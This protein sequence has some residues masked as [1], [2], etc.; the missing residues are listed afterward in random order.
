MPQKRSRLLRA[1]RTDEAAMLVAMWRISEAP[2]HAIGGGC[3]HL[4]REG[5]QPTWLL[6]RAV[7]E[8][9]GTLLR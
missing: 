3:Y 5:T 2:P 1:V 4:V 8:R 9:L 6:P 7:R